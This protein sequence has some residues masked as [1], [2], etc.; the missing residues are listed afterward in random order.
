MK[1]SADQGGYPQRLKA[2]V[3][4]TPQDVQNSSYPTKAELLLYY[5][6]YCF[7]I[8]LKYFLVLKGVSPFR[9]CSLVFLLTENNTI[10]SPAGCTFDVILMSFVQ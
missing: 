9:S 8:L 3:D 10:L 1:N 7:I 2:K 5:C 6:N 4:S